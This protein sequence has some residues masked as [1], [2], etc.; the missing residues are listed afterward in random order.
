A[1]SAA[2]ER[3]SDPITTEKIAQYLFFAQWSRLR[4]YA[5]EKGIAIIGDVPIFLALDSADVWCNQSMFKLNADG[6]P[7]VVSGVPPD[8]FSKTGQL[9]G[10]PI[11]DWEAMRADGFGWWTARIAAALRQ[12][13]VVRIDH[14]RGFAAAW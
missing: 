11:Y 7:A 10:N 9:W 13:D 12:V 1:L 2:A 6:T 14:F 3:L 4:S 8:Y 5:N